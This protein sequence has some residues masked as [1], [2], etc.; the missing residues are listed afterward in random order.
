MTHVKHHGF[1][2]D[3]WSSIDQKIVLAVFA[4]SLIGI[5][6]VTTSSP[7]IAVRIGVKPSYFIIRQ[8]IYIG[9]TTIIIF[10]LSLFDPKSIKRFAIIG[11]LLSIV[12]LVLV[13][14]YGYEVKGAKRWI[15]IAGCS[16]QPSEILKPFLW[17]VLGWI[18]SLRQQNLPSFTISLLL[19]TIVILLLIIQPDFGTCLLISAT[20]GIQ[21]FIAGIPIIC[22]V[23]AVFLSSI[24]IIASY[25]WLPHVNQRINAF[26][27][28][29]ENYQ[30][31]KSLQAFNTG[32]LYGKGLGEGSIK[33]ALPDSHTDFIFAVAGE[34]L[35]GIT[36]LI[37]ALIFAFI[38]IRGL[39]KLINESDQYKLLSVTGI[40]SQIGLQSIINMGVALDLFPTKGMT[41][42][43]VSY[44]G[45]SLI[46]I[47]IGIGMLL[48]FTR[49]N[50]YI[51][52][53]KM[54]QLNI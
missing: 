36:C 54:R 2:N 35:G 9:I 52:R 11:F 16:I 37:I 15:R 47:S 17:V 28:S 30:A 39:L 46:S 29:G 8:F 23:I 31:L 32:G 3:W 48:A 21:V 4:L 12:L 13:K 43:F 14:F 10:A 51:T 34:E 22:V 33:Q 53:Y 45:S 38:V 20:V 7:A 40:L 18:L 27:D 44:G 41:L 49:H 5:L 6:L 25:L 24:G 42:P 19:Y 26:L 1:I 50:P